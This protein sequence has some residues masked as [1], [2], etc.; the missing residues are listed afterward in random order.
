MSS[1]STAENPLLDLP[2]VGDLVALFDKCL[3]D[4]GFS[5]WGAE[6]VE[7]V[8]LTTVSFAVLT[9]VVGRLIPYLS[10]RLINSAGQWA[11]AIPALLLAPEWLVT[12]LLGRFG[13][14]PGSML[15]GYGDGVFALTDAI[16][17]LVVVVL[18]L[19]GRAGKFPHLTVSLFFILGMLV[20]NSESCVGES[21]PCVSP[22]QQ[23]I[24]MAGADAE[25]RPE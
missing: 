21:D 25:R 19:L 24:Q 16:G 10:D 7:F 3:L 6:S 23:W 14:A 1:S 2:I 13:R 12:K 17:R 15:Y 4:L 11:A 8:V 9:A 5:V 20:W 18:R 22:V